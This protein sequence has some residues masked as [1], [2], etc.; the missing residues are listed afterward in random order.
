MI[1]PLLLS[2]SLSKLCLL[3]LMDNLEKT[4]AQFIDFDSGECLACG[5]VHHSFHNIDETEKRRKNNNNTSPYLDR[6]FWGAFR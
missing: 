3:S 6:L 4:L 5:H 1:S 2:S